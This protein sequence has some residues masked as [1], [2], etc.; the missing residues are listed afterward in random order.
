MN[1]VIPQAITAVDLYD[2]FDD[3]NIK[4]NEIDIVKMS[5]LFTNCFCNILN[6][7]S[8]FIIYMWFNKLY[9]LRNSFKIRYLDRL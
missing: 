5:T 6:T 3:D 9:L 7:S 8:T 1:F 4:I 2:V